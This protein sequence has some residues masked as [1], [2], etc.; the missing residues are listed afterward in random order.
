MNI[1]LSPLNMSPNNYFKKFIEIEKK[2]TE[3]VPDGPKW[4]NLSGY[5]VKHVVCVIIIYSSLITSVLDMP[6]LFY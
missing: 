2:K 5:S 3:W 1:A 4:L 6:V